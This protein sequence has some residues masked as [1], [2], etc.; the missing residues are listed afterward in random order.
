L[1]ILLPA[2]DV[3]ASVAFNKM[4][5]HLRKGEAD[6]ARRVA[7]QFLLD[8]S[9]ITLADIELL[10]SGLTRLRLMRTGIRHD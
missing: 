5:T 2:A 3:D 6:A 1:A 10:T 9:L 8:N 7:D 4:D